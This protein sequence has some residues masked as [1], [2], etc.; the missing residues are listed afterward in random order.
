MFS[1]IR[2]IGTWPGP[3]IMTW[4]SCSHAIRVSS[5]NVSS[6]ANCASSF[7][8]RSSPAAGHHERERDVVSGHDLADL[9]EAGVE[10]ALLVVREHHLA[11]I[12]PPRETMPVTRLAVSGMYRRRT[13][14]VD[15]K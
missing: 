10:E 1:L 5:P 11:M 4:Q 8:S 13:P 15:V 9:A 2:C 6:S 7:A 14:G 12:E 3:S